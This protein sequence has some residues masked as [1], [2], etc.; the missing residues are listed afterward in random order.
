M[1]RKRLVED[2]LP[3]GIDEE[4][5]LIVACDRDPQRVPRLGRKHG[6]TR[7]LYCA[8]IPMRWDRSDTGRNRAT[9]H[10]IAFC[11]CA[12]Q[13]HRHNAAR[14]DVDGDCNR[15]TFS[16]CKTAM[17]I[18]RASASMLKPRR[19]PRLQ[20][21]SLEPE[22]NEQVVQRLTQ[23]M[24]ICESRRKAIRCHSRTRLTG[25]CANPHRPRRITVYAVE[26]LS[27]WQRSL[28]FRDSQNRHLL[29]Q[30][31][32]DLFHSL[33]APSYTCCKRG[34]RRV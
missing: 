5:G 15:R 28:F 9:D 24:S 31:L 32:H 4:P 30:A 25:G 3:R 6:T 22:E 8:R 12:V 14:V 19:R 16:T 21:C 7:H 26:V 1:P 2:Q 23:E 27:E 29:R 34:R 33:P 17:K 20:H 10:T 11:R 13:Q 18:A